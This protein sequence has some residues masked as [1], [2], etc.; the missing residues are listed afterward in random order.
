MDAIIEKSKPLLQQAVA[1]D[2][3]GC[4][5]EAVSRYIEG[6]GILMQALSCSDASSDKRESLKVTIGKYMTRAECLKSS[7]K[8]KVD[9]VEQLQIKAGTVNYKLMRV[10]AEK[11]S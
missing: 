1:L 2:K 7:V 3:D 11:L 9:F 4:R 10:P 5:S 8:V 6:I